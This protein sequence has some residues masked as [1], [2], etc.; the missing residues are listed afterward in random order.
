MSAIHLL[1]PISSTP[2]RN[3]FDTNPY[4][5][6]DSERVRPSIPHESAISINN[7]RFFRPRQTSPASILSVASAPLPYNNENL[8]PAS[9]DG[10]FSQPQSRLPSSERPGT[11]TCVPSKAQSGGLVDRPNTSTATPI[12]PNQF[13]TLPK[14]SEDTN[15]DDLLQAALEDLEKY[16]VSRSQ[17]DG[18][19]HNRPSFEARATARSVTSPTPQL[20]SVP[21]VQPAD[22]PANVKTG[23]YSTPHRKRTTTQTTSSE[24]SSTP[25]LS[26]LLLRTRQSTTSSGFVHT[27]KTAS[28]SNLSFGAI[29][30]RL[31]HGQ[32][33]ESRILFG[34]HS[35]FSTD[36]DRPATVSS[37]D[38]NAL[39]RGVKRRR[40][41]EELVTTEESY[42]ADLKALVYLMSTLLASVTSIP[43]RVRTL[44]QRNVFDLLHLHERLVES[45]HR[46]AFKAAAR[47]WADTLSPQRLE[48]PRRHIRWRSLDSQATYRPSPGHGQGRSSVDSVN[49]SRTK[50][51]LV[52]TEPADLSDIV[53]IFR[54]AMG[55]FF[56]YEEY[57]ANHEIIA[58]DLQ[59]HLPNLWSSY[60]SGMESLARSLA[61]IDKR[62]DDGS[63]ALTVGD[64]LIK[65]IQRI[66]KYP[67][68]FKELLGYTPVSDDPSV[69]VE[70]ESLLQ[71]MRDVV[72]SVNHAT[73]NPETR[74][75]IHRRWALRSRLL[76]ERVALSHED[77]RSLGDIVLCG[78]LHVAY[79]TRHGVTGSYGLC[80]LFE[81][82]LLVALPVA[83][84]AKFD[85]V[86]LV[87][88]QDLKVDSASDGK[89][90]R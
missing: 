8:A 7:T 65:P 31:R 82:S 12:K 90:E 66:C 25:V 21:H 26:P 27:I 16:K 84:S 30:K 5:Y 41:L 32:S 1:P 57:C 6:H 58:R 74:L 20:K 56:A 86:A 62:A 89:G 38:E 60:E 59:R 13:I 71:C 76:F 39:W 11:S 70:L 33:S 77:F 43:T 15:K 85:I 4:S 49:L 10:F 72:E 73:Q 75:Q 81:Q 79:Q 23:G 22:Q 46:A 54:T 87:H 53:T 42:V 68:M 18:D 3:K 2:F 14:P 50:A 52:G 24:I 55:N 44:V 17:R 29:S 61:A 78:V 37:I 36:S 67:L 51:R 48:S 80:V 63:K 47:K 9:I 40:V 34:S 45:L 35:R 28:F 19:I 69:H 83:A 88:L 64:L